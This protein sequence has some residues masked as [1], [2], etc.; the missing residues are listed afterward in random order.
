MLY[1]SNDLNTATEHLRTAIELGA[2]W[3]NPDALAGDY[4]GLAQICQATGDFDGATSQLRKV[5]QMANERDLTPMTANLVSVHRARL[6]L[7]QEDLA[8]AARWALNSG[9]KATDSPTFI[10]EYAYLTLARVLIAQGTHGDAMR[11]LRR[12][13][14]AARESKRLGRVI[15]VLALQ[16]LTLQA[17]GDRTGALDVLEQALALGKPEGYVRVFLD[18][19][20]PM[21]ALLATLCT[22]RP[23]ANPEYTERLLVAFGVEKDDQRPRPKRPDS[24]LVE[25]LSEREL[26]VLRLVA[27]GLTNQE[28][29]DE[30]V[31]AVS[32]VKSHTNH[33]YGKL[34]VKNRTQA[35][36]RAGAL[37]LL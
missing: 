5:E 37:R 9:L 20:A 30:L 32:T 28:I 31:I 36:A 8:Q 1:Q 4:L 29:A 35:I 13:L 11:L 14:H 24:S 3:G 34:G 18:E 26:E 12:L 21:A 33:I 6:A 22:R 16:A 15:E 2:L 25:P 7:A 23:T 17:S 10:Q 27:G 19:G